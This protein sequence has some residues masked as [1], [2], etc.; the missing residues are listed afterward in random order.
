MGRI[1]P[2]FIAFILTVMLVD[3]ITSETPIL[4]AIKDVL[5]VGLGAVFGQMASQL[6]FDML[7]ETSIGPVGLFAAAVTAGL[8]VGVGIALLIE[9]FV[10]LFKSPEFKS[11]PEITVSL[12]TPPDGAKIVRQVM[13]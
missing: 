9:W 2:V 5:E 7:L 13:Q 12:L 1:A 4:T 3:I 6:A 11:W 10:S 8:I